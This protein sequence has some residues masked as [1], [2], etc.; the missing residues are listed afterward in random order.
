MNK[1]Y[2]E[3]IH[4]GNRLDKRTYAKDVLDALANLVEGG[5]P[6]SGVYLIKQ[7]DEWSGDAALFNADEV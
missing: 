5:Y 6:A 4:D 7:V 2:I 3:L 1:W